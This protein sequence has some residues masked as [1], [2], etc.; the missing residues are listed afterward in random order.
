[1]TFSIL[2]TAPSRARETVSDLEKRLDVMA[3]Q[4]EYNARY[5]ENGVPVIID[6]SRD[7]VKEIDAE[8][9]QA[10]QAPARSQA[11]AS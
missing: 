2:T 10:L 7:V 9:G 1:M 6:P 8:F 3:K 4:A 5:V 11:K